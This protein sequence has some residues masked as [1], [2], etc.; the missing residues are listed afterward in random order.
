MLK[1][2]YIFATILSAKYSTDDMNTTDFAMNTTDFAR[3]IVVNLA[4]WADLI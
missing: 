1:L 4:Y 3:G 2:I